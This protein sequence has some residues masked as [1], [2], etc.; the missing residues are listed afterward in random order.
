MVQQ[1]GDSAKAIA[2]PSIGDCFKSLH[3]RKTDYAVVPFENSTNGQVVFTYDLLR[4]WFLGRQ[5]EPTFGIVGEQ[6]VAIQHNVLSTAPNLA[7]ITHLYSHPQVWGQVSNYLEL[8]PLKN[9][10]KTD[11]P[12]TAKAAELVVG[13]KLGTSAAIC[14]RMCASIYNLPVLDAN[15]EDVKGNSTRFLVLGYE[16]LDEKGTPVTSL[17]FVLNRDDPGALVSALDSFRASSINLTSIA[18]RPL[19]LARW[20]YVF[21]VEALSGQHSENMQ[22]SISM[23]RESCSKVVVLGTFCRATD[24][25]SK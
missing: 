19:G 6:Y 7:S 15:V 13:D 14:S 10:I 11:C 8:G 1:F 23:L 3:S 9:A 25:V 24:T 12:S 20:L 5:E 18:S 22:M 21:F 2:Q 16:P 4:D 17:M